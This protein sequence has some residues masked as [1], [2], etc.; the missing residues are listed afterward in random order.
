MKRGN[1]IVRLKYIYSHNENDV[2]FEY[3]LM[4]YKDASFEL[5]SKTYQLSVK[6]HP[7]KWYSVKVFWEMPTYLLL[8]YSTNKTTQITKHPTFKIIGAIFSIMEITLV[9]F[10]FYHLFK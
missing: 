9:L 10:G 8:R 7:Y 3:K 6:R 4:P 2:W 5:S 1:K